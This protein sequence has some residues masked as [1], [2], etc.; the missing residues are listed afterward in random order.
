MAP[1]STDR[2]VDLTDAGSM[3]AAPG[4]LPRAEFVVQHLHGPQLPGENR[5]HVAFTTVGLHR[6]ELLW[7]WIAIADTQMSLDLFSGLCEH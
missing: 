6:G 7:R 1:D 5:S 2:R 3:R 4:I